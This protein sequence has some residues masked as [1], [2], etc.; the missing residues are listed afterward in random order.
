MT[1]TLEIINPPYEIETYRV[2][3]HLD[4]PVTSQR[5]LDMILYFG[6]PLILEF[7][8]SQGGADS[9]IIHCPCGC[10]RPFSFA[11]VK[12][13]NSHGFSPP[14]NVVERNKEGK[15]YWPPFV[16]PCGTQFSISLEGKPEILPEKTTF[17]S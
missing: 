5:A 6:W 3:Q 13:I 17:L 8:S 9:G 2:F 10:T 15:A 14:Q 12:D 11:I 7:G 16:S 4:I 1:S